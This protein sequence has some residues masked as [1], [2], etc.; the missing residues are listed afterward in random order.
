MSDNAFEVDLADGDEGTDGAVA[1]GDV[2]ELNGH[3]AVLDEGEG[4]ADLESVVEPVAV[5]A[6]GNED[7]ASV[8]LEALRDWQEGGSHSAGGDRDG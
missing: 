2:E 7:G 8:A 6:A 3:L 5:R 4:A 1:V